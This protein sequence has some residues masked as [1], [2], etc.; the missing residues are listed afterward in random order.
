MRTIRAAACTF[1][2]AA[3]IVFA[4]QPG[5]PAVKVFPLGSGVT[6]PE[7]L[8]HVTTKPYV[9]DHCT[10]NE[11]GKVTFS[12][13]VDSGGV[14]RNIYFLNPL[15]NDLDVLA[16]K[17]VIEDRFKPG[18][19]DGKPVAVAASLELS[20]HTCLRDEKDAQGKP[21]IVLHLSAEPEQHLAP[22]TSPPS[23]VVLVSGNGVTPSPDEPN[24][25]VYKV[26]GQVTPPHV[27]RPADSTIALARRLLDLGDYK[28][29]VLVDRYGMPA[30][31]K[32]LDAA[33]PGR[34]Q[35]IAVIVRLWRFKPA[36]LNGEPVPTRVELKMSF[37]GVRRV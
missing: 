31:L 24:P 25:V 18:T 22:P 16:L 37:M 27:F 13:I 6:S 12:L 11:Q 28:V 23:L 32:I 2:L 5:E 35:Q 21:Q 1:V 10:G 19:Q 34:E 33:Q 4:Q 17:H 8:P 15:G 29:S 14:P 9:S 30:S 36:I 3:A 7:P 20:L 26:G